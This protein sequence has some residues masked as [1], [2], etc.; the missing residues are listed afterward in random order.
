MVSMIILLAV[1]TAGPLEPSRVTASSALPRWKGYTF[2][3]AN[4]ID[5]K[6]DT[7][8]QPKSAQGGVG[9]WFELEFDTR[10]RV[11]KCSIANGLQ[12]KD[13]L[14]DLFLLNNRIQTAQMVF[15]DGSSLALEFEPNARGMIEF[16]VPKQLTR[17]IRVE[18]DS[19]FKGTKFKDLAVSEIR[20]EGEEAPEELDSS[21][22]EV[23]TPESD[24]ALCSRLHK[25]CGPWTGTDNCERKRTVAS[26]GTCGSGYACS[27]NGTCDAKPP[28]Q[29]P[30]LSVRAGA[31][32]GR[33]TIEKD[34]V[35]DKWTWLIWQRGESSR[36]FNWADAKSYCRSLNLGGFSSDWRLPSWK[37]LMS[38]SDSHIESTKSWYWSATPSAEVNG[39]AKTGGFGTIFSSEKAVTDD[40]VSVRCVRSSPIPDGRYTI[41]T[42]TVMDNWTWLIWQRAVPDKEFDWESAKRYCKSLN[43]GG[44]SSG[45]RLPT[46]KELEALIDRR[47][48][49]P[50]IDPKA[51]PTP[52]I[53]ATAVAVDGSFWSATP[54]IKGHAYF[55]SFDLRIESNQVTTDNP[56]VVRCVTTGPRSRYTIGINVVKDNQTGLIW[57]RAAPNKI[58]NW[59]DAKSYCQ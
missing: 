46:M 49:K 33:F 18:V 10:V 44:F 19:V 12:L 53:D 39:Y 31:P 26:C 4:L 8:W 32:E 56:S 47:F 2:A 27:S 58:F 34:T 13:E 50:S 38:M 42:D 30:E 24:V 48:S 16:P 14:G 17:T 45:W 41:G 40:T 54:G 9:E 23:C 21:K 43:L 11:E 3:P 22:R 52:S 37:E 51:F 36:K 15:S 5:G 29:P 20:C 59:A 6:L 28:S 7:S 35:L 57:Q 1:L 55:V 25:T